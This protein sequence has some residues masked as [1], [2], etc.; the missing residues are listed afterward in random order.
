MYFLLFLPN[1][2]FVCA[3]DEY[4]V[5]C[6][7]SLADTVVLPTSGSIFGENHPIFEQSRF[8]EYLDPL[9]DGWIMCCD[10]RVNGFQNHYQKT[11]SPHK[12]QPVLAVKVFIS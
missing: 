3:G 2:L 6:G 8:L 10:M 5:D 7:V 9:H 12:L 1:F 11:R 4:D